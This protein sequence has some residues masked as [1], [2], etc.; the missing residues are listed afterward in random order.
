MSITQQ[1]LPAKHLVL[2]SPRSPPGTPRRPGAERLWAIAFAVPYIAVF[3]AFAA[4]PIGYALWM[5]GKPAHFATLIDDPLYLIALVNTLLFVGI[6][7]NL[8]MF[9]ALVLSGYFARRRW[10]IKAILFF[11]LLPWALPSVQAYT[12][13]HWMLIGDLGFTNSVLRELFGIEGPLWFNHRWLALGCDIAAN[14]WKWMPFWTLIFLAGRATIPDDLKDAAAIDGATGWRQF[15]YVTFPLLANLYLI[16]T[17]LSAIWT[18]GD[19][20]TVYFV[21]SGS[22]TMTTDVLATLGFRYTIDSLRP[23]L[24]VTA[25]LSLL[26][27][28][29]PVVLL[30]LRRLSLREIQL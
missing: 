14:I 9:L 24:G 17:L 13:F 1:A 19:F 7:V 29:I 28:L 16:C 23:E 12:S 27:I 30:L 5:G 25:I 22:P 18:V 6:T 10:W 26:P 21:S 11:Y 2:G 8:Q 3:A 4:Y 20:N 15:V